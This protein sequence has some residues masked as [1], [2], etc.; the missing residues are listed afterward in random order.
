MRQAG[1]WAGVA[2]GNMDTIDA[3]FCAVLHRGWGC[4]IRIG[5]HRLPALQVIAGGAVS[6]G[7]D[8][9]FAQGIVLA[10]VAIAGS[11]AD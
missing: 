3:V 2:L 1:G 11:I 6:G 9:G 7:A 4:A 8:R 10:S 5:D